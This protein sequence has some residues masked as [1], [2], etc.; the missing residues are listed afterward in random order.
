MNPF[1][2]MVIGAILGLKRVCPKCKRVQIISSEKRQDT[3]LCKFC[4][5][6]LPPKK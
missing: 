5:A 4:G 1:I 3:V 6:K 2:A